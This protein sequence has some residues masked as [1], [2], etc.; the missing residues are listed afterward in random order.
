MTESPINIAYRIET[1]RL[2]MRCWSPADAPVLRAALDESDQH[3]RP[4]IPWMKDEP[5]SLD[6]TAAG[7][8]I[9]RAN[10]DLGKDFWYAIFD[11]EEQTLIGEI[12]LMTRAGPGALEVGYWIDKSCEG[13]GYASEAT[14]VMIRVAF[15]IAKV[16]RIEVYC[17]PEN[18]ASVAIPRKLGF[19]HEATLARR[20]NDSEGDVH[21]MMVWTLFKDACPDSPASHQELRA[22][23][24][25]G[26]QIL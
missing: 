16:E 6:E 22:F 26:R 19:L 12:G 1:D 23:D 17:A 5:K 15:E 24:C 10:F 18:D 3:L 13:K 11:R 14:A 8:R 7:L 2:L 4:W 9:K 25:L 20:Y 21:D